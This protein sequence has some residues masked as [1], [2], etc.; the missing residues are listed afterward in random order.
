[1]KVILKIRKIIPTVVTGASFVS[2]GLG[3]WYKK[4]RCTQNISSR[5]DWAQYSDAAIPSYL[6]NWKKVI[7]EDFG[8]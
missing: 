1:V 5:W 7:V 6:M 2:R 4:G 3:H 8:L